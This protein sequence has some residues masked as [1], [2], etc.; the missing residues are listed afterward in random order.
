MAQMAIKPLKKIN[1]GAFGVIRGMS[2][3]KK[4]EE[5][6]PRPAALMHDIFHS[7]IVLPTVNME[8]KT[9]PKKKD[10]TIAG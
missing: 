8:D 4:K 5:T 2:P 10:Q 3:N 1:H 6:A 9:S 7:L